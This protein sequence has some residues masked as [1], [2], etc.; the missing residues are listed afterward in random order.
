[1]V[2]ASK[3]EEDIGFDDFILVNQDMLDKI[4]LIINSLFFMNLK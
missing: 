3:D 4:D 2:M 1:M